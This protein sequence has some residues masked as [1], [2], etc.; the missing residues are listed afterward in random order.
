MLVHG[1]T[2][3]NFH[4]AAFLP[5]NRHKR[6]PLSSRAFKNGEFGARHFPLQTLVE[7]IT[8]EASILSLP[9]E[10]IHIKDDWNR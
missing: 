5:V 6:N 3:L 2:E 10:R 7:R 4:S 9:P 1:A 8:Q